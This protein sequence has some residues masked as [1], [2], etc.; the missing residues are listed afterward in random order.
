MLRAGLLASLCALL[1]SS[2][3]LG[4]GWTGPIEINHV[5]GEG[6]AS[7]QLVSSPDGRRIVLIT[8][9]DHEGVDVYRWRSR[10]R[11]F[12][13]RQSVP[14]ST[15]ADASRLPLAVINN[16]GAVGLAW[17]AT[18]GGGGDGID[19]CFC[20]IRATLLRPNGHFEHVW[21]PAHATSPEKEISGLQ[22]A[23][24]GQVRVLWSQ[25]ENLKLWTVSAHGRVTRTRRI[26]PRGSPTPAGASLL[27]EERNLPVVIYPDLDDEP[28]STDDATPLYSTR[29]PYSMA[30]ELGVVPNLDWLGTDMAFASDGKGARLFLSTGWS[31][32]TLEGIVPQVSKPA[33]QPIAVMSLDAPAAYPTCE[34][35]ATMNTRGATLVAWACDSSSTTSGGP[36]SFAQAVLLDSHGRVVA[37]SRQKRRG[38]LSGEPP[39]VALDKAGRGIV[40]LQG[41][42][43]ANPWG[44]L[45]GLRLA[46]RRFGRWQTIVNSG[47]ESL[48]YVSAAVTPSGRALVT[49]TEEDPL[50]REGVLVAESKQAK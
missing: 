2:N 7:A 1:V 4:A 12:S 29:A 13:S 36:T 40:A 11:K 17:L 31:T 45:I 19:E 10:D 42:S 48:A 8:R 16:A 15:N 21:E 23:S 30:S 44:G 33:L 35:S 38:I 18:N 20:A 9:R 41:A 27:D 43:E 14:R 3:A 24:S 50:H 22:L 46:D 37:T 5:A 26:D 47:M 39:A 28:G 25:I 6:L 34:L 32:G 49:W